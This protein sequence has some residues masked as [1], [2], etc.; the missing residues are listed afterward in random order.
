[1]SPISPLRSRST[2]MPVPDWARLL[3]CT[4]RF[5]K[6]AHCAQVGTAGPASEARLIQS[7]LFPKRQAYP[8]N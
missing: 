8:P 5:G 6:A 1:V 4:E 7:G 3:R 2:G